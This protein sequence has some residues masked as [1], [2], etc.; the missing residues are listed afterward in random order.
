LP[1]LDDPR[2]DAEEIQ[3]SADGLRDDVVHRSRTM[4]EAWHRRHQDR[5]IGGGACHEIDMTGVQRRLAEHQHDASTLLEA[6]IGG[7]HDQF[8]VEAIGDAAER[9]DRAGSDQHAF[10]AERTA[11]NRGADVFVV[12]E[13]VAEGSHP[14]DGIVGFFGDGAGGRGRQ[15]DMGLDAGL[16]TENFQCAYAVDDT[17]GARDGHD[18]ALLARVL[19]T[20]HG[21]FSERSTPSNAVSVRD[22]SLVGKIREIVRESYQNRRED[23]AGRTANCHYSLPGSACSSESGSLMIG[24]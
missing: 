20:R 15:N 17:R 7:S 24:V 12:V 13:L 10:G 21:E 22:A 2:I 14:I 16:G 3:G 18:Q 4:V 23:G 1:A 11:G 19:C 9:F 8:F 6:H 5:S